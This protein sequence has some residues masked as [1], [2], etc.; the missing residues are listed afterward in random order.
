MK[1]SGG[2]KK[3]C[4]I[5]QHALCNKACCTTLQICVQFVFEIKNTDL[6]QLKWIEVLLLPNTNKK[7]SAIFSIQKNLNNFLT[8][9]YNLVLILRN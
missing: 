2:F 5:V 3:Y 4:N 7:N 1:N 6:G 9:R 8:K